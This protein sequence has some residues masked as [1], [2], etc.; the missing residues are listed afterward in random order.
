MVTDAIFADFNND[1]WGDLI[2]VGEWMPITIFI[3][4]QGAFY[5]VQR[6]KPDGGTVLRAATSM[7]MATPISSLAILE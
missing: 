5:K 4:N 7:V 3:N 2:V 6:I 1:G